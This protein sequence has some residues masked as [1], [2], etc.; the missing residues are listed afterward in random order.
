MEI[1]AGGLGR[2][3]PMP[4]PEEHPYPGNRQKEA[5]LDG[6]KDRHDQFLVIADQV[7]EDEQDH[8]PD[9]PA[10]RGAI[11]RWA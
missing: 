1:F 4:V 2:F 7:A 6:R 3:F 10:R 5:Y 9:R 11:R 8:R